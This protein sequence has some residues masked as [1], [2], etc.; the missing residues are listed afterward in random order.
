M[1]LPL[2]HLLQGEIVFVQLAAYFGYFNGFCFLHKVRIILTAVPLD[3]SNTCEN[4][5]F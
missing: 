3:L 5:L 2:S 1:V 4:S